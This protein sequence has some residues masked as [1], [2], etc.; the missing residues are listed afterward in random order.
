MGPVEV[1]QLAN[2]SRLMIRIIND[3]SDSNVYLL[4]LVKETISE[5]FLKSDRPG[6]T[7]ILQPPNV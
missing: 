5:A 7:T 3:L 6:S 2:S 1:T 4:I